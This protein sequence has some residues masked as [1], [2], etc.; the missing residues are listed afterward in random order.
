MTTSKKNPPLMIKLM[1]ILDSCEA[2]EPSGSDAI[3]FHLED[4]SIIKMT[5]TDEVEGA[6]SARH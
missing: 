1:K 4:G 2:M 3:L 5:L 6:G